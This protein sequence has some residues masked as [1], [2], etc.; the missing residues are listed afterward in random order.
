MS[1]TVYV[2][3]LDTTCGGFFVPPAGAM[4]GAPLTTKFDC[5]EELFTG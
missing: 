1:V 4:G 3:A 2:D 5:L